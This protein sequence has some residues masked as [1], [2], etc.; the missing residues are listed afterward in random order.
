MTNIWRKHIR[1]YP[2]ALR[3]KKEHAIICSID[4][5][6]SEWLPQLPVA[7]HHSD[8]SVVEFYD[9]LAL[10]YHKS[11]LSKN[12]WELWWMRGFFYSMTHPTLSEGWSGN[13]ITQWSQECMLLMT[14]QQ[15][16]TVKFSENLA[17]C[18]VAREDKWYPTFGG[19]PWSTWSMAASDNGIIRHVS[20]TQMSHPINNVQLRML[21]LQQK[22]IRNRSTPNQ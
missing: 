3:S 22:Q 4:H 13:T 19:R 14:L 5:T 18:V 7:H 21:W 12:A 9:E 6:T 11:Q 17:C 2:G 1:F 15:S 20:W 10:H 8:L 16:S